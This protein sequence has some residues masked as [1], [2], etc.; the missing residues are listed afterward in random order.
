MHKTI[1]IDVDE[2]ITSIISKIRKEGAPDIF[3]VVPKD[4]ML[5]QGMINLKLLK[6]EADKIR[7]ELILITPN[8]HAK[9]VIED[10]G[11]EVRDGVTRKSSVDNQAQMNLKQ[12][13][14]DGK[15][16]ITDKAIQESLEEIKKVPDTGAIGTAGFYAETKKELPKTRPEAEMDFVNK[17]PQAE[18][19]L[20][21]TPVE[22]QRSNEKKRH[23]FVKKEKEASSQDQSSYKNHPSQSVKPSGSHHQF[24]RDYSQQGAPMM[25]AAS[26]PEGK[27]NSKAIFKKREAEDFFSSSPGE[28]EVLKP[29]KKTKS[30]IGAANFFRKKV[31]VILIVLF[32]LAG[33][34]WWIY[35][36]W[37]KI[38]ITVYPKGEEISETVD[39]KV[40][41]NKNDELNDN[42]INGRI[43]ELEI[44]ETTSFEPSSEK[45]SSDKGK[46][47][48]KVI[49]YNK[50]SSSQQPLVVTTRVLSKEGKLFR[51]SKDIVV[52][53]M[54][55][56]EPGKI[57]VSVM[58]DQPGEDFNINASTFTIEGFK[59]GPK[60]DKFEVVSEESMVGGEDSTDNKKV[61]VATQQ[62][63]EDAREKTLE[64]LDKSIEKKIDEK[65]GPEESYAIDSVEREIVK[66]S[67]SCE[68]NEIANDC[69]FTVQEKIKLMVFHEEDVKSFAIEALESKKESGYEL[70]GDSVMIEH[71]KT[72]MDFE[73][74]ELKLKIEA[75]G[76]IWPQINEENMKK[77]IANKQEEEMKNFLSNYAE[78]KKAEIEISPVW[79]TFIPV[80]ESKITIEKIQQD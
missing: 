32:G 30:S 76:K 48:G 56:E 13:S 4:A 31:V 67:S 38:A 51:L 61:K 8:K 26:Y 77:G 35:L 21:Q 70:E 65:I 63:I 74:R 29:K 50:F 73:N 58:A 39:L 44:E 79:L 41:A 36:N 33:F 60:Y 68:A 62:D 19:D 64:A 34:S 24:K 5:L 1:Y 7:K 18:M 11:M 23:L 6:K 49:I 12:K 9:K 45:F 72:V 2:E 14:K 47:Q 28:E 54:K 46:A 52:P 75:T 66:S 25:A 55:N 57:E 17:N 27:N 71:L 22:A 69:K 78:I 20:K 59:G 15:E 37:P 53:G 43:Q 16:G 80:S 42:E 10:L 40:M 3:L